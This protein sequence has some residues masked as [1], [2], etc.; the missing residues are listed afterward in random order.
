[1]NDVKDL[2]EVLAPV[3]EQVGLYLEEVELKPAGKRTLLRVTVDLPDGP[4]GVD[5]DQLV[6]VTRE[7]SAFLDESPEAPKGQYVLEVSTPGATRKL[8]TPR[9]FRRAEGRKVVLNTAAGEVTGHVESVE[10]D[11][12]T[13]S[14]GGH[15]SEIAISDVTNARMEVE[16]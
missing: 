6:D 13:I 11:T 14:S 16:L 15:T 4:G 2:H 10:G 12:L 7:V 1:M 9:H 5:S 8:T 3:V